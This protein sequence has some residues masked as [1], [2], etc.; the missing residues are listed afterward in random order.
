[1]DRETLRARLAVS[2][3]RVAKDRE[4]IEAQRALIR[5]QRR[6]HFGLTTSEASLRT[7]LEIQAQHI[8]ESDRIR[9]QLA[10]FHK[11]A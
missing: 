5:E 4:V 2:E 11:A 8:T 3:G 9:K 6:R 7:M 1:M 10:S